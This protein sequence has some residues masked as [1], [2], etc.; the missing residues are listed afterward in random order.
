MDKKLLVSVMMATPVAAFAQQ[1]EQAVSNWTPDHGYLVYGINATTEKGGWTADGGMETVSS[2]GTVIT[3]IPG[4]GSV[5]HKAELVKGNYTLKVDPKSL[6]NAKIYFNDKL[7][8]LDANG[9]VVIPENEILTE[10]SITAA[11]TI[12]VK[13]I[14]PA[15]DFTVGKITLTLDF[16]FITVK[17]ALDIKLKGITL[18]TI[19]ESLKPANPS[20]EAESLRTQHGTLTAEVAAIQAKIDGIDTDDAASMESSYKTYEFEKYSSGDKI[21]LEIDALDTKVSEYNAAVTAENTRYAKY[22]SDKAT[23]AGLM[24]HISELQTKLNNNAAAPGPEDPG[25]LAYAQ[26]FFDGYVSTAQTALDDYKAQVEAAYDAEGDFANVDLSK[27]TIKVKDVE[28]DIDAVAWTKPVNDYNAYQEFWGEDSTSEL[29]P[30][31]LQKAYDDD[32]AKLNYDFNVDQYKPNVPYDADDMYD[33]TVNIWLDYVGEVTAKLEAA[34]KNNTGYAIVKGTIAGSYDNLAEA[35]EEVQA[36]LKAFEKIMK[37]AYDDFD[38]QNAAWK[39]AVGN[40][41]G[42][43]KQF[44][45]DTKF[46]SEEGYTILAQDKKDAIEAAKKTYQDALDALWAYD[47][48][49]HIVHKLDVTVQDYTDLLDAVSTAQKNFKKAVGDVADIITYSNKLEDT[50]KD[51]QNFNKTYDG[52]ERLMKQTYDDLKSAIANYQSDPT[53]GFGET[54]DGIETFA[55]TWATVKSAF[56]AAQTAINECS[57]ELD[58]YKTDIANA[59]ILGDNDFSLKTYNDEATGFAEKISEKDDSYTAQ[60]TAAASGSANPQECYKKATAVADQVRDDKLKDQ[61]VAADLAFVQNLALSNYTY[62]GGIIKKIAEAKVTFAG[63]PGIN[64]VTT[65]EI[66]EGVT[67]YEKLDKPGVDTSKADC[68]VLEADL[69]ALYNVYADALG[70]LKIIED[71]KKAYA[72]L[73]GA[74]A[75][76]EENIKTL[77]ENLDKLTSYPATDYYEKNEIPALQDTHDEIDSDLTDAHV[78]NDENFGKVLKLQDRFKIEIENLDDAIKDLRDAIVAN[79]EAY[80]AQIRES[81]KVANRANAIIA[82][83]DAQT[84][85]Q[86]YS[87][88]CRQVIVEVLKD[89]AATNIEI[90]GYFAKGEAADYTNKFN[91]IFTG[92]LQKINDAYNLETGGL[93]KAVEEYNTDYLNNPQLGVRPGQDYLYDAYTKAVETVNGYLYDIKNAGYAAVLKGVVE[94]EKVNTLYNLQKIYNKIYQLTKNIDAVKNLFDSR[95]VILS[96]NVLIN[97]EGNEDLKKAFADL[98]GYRQD[99]IDLKNEIASELQKVNDACV[100]AAAKY[101]SKQYALAQSVLD[102]IK[103][104]FAKANIDPDDLEDYTELDGLLLAADDWNGKNMP[105][106]DATDDKKEAYI[107]GLAAIMTDDIDVIIAKNVTD[108]VNLACNN[109]WSSEYTTVKSTLT[110]LSKELETY[111]DDPNLSART[112]AFNQHVTKVESLNNDWNRYY[113]YDAVDYLVD[114]LAELNAE[115]AAAQEIVKQSKEDNDKNAANAAARDLL[116]PMIGDLDLDLNYLR[117]YGHSREDQLKKYSSIQTEI[118]QLSYSVAHNTDLAGDG[119]Y[120]FDRVFVAYKYIENIEKI[121]DKIEAAYEDV[122]KYEYEYAE[123]LL[124]IVRT[125]FNN[126]LTVLGADNKEMNDYDTAINTQVSTLEGLK[127]SYTYDDRDEVM[128]QLMNVE[129]AL[130]ELIVELQAKFKAADGQQPDTHKAMLKEVKEAFDN[131]QASFNSLNSD[132]EN[133]VTEYDVYGENTKTLM[134]GALGKLQSRLD[135]VF[136][137]FANQGSALITDADGYEYEISEIANAIA[138]QQT[139]Y[140]KYEEKDSLDFN[141]DEIYFSLTQKLEVYKDNVNKAYKLAVEANVAHRNYANY[142]NLTVWIEELEQALNKKNAYKV[143]GGVHDLTSDDNLDNLVK[144]NGV[145]TGTSGKADSYVKTTLIYA[146]KAKADNVTEL[147]QSG[148]DMLDDGTYANESELKTEIDDLKTE[149]ADVNYTDLINRHWEY[150]YQE[151]NDGTQALAAYKGLLV[152]FA[153]LENRV[154]GVLDKIEASAYTMGDVDLDGK[155]GIQD[156]NTVAGW[157][158]KWSSSAEGLFDHLY[159]GTLNQRRMALAA[160]FEDYHAINIGDIVSIVRLFQS[161]GTATPVNAAERINALRAPKA[162][163]ENGALS[164]VYAGEVNGLDRYA[165]VLNNPAELVA[166]QF[167]INLP[168]GCRVADVTTTERSS[169]HEL[170]YDDNGERLRILLYSL[171]NAAFDGTDGAIA[172]IDVEGEVPALA[173][174]TLADS[175]ARTY[176][177]SASGTT[178]TDMIIEGASKAKDMI[179]DAAGRMYDKLQRG[180]NIIRNADGSTTKKISK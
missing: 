18:E 147:A 48:E 175:N 116:T 136:A 170:G 3:C 125:A 144:G 166:G 51:I 167:D 87:N 101:F 90:N 29:T 20:D 154:N 89:L 133:G 127:T 73:T 59:V 61:I 49:K 134:A 145:F 35:Q 12:V 21:D 36:R 13:H 81:D 66:P 158:L 63:E 156:I 42:V 180:I 16:N 149:I 69:V 99:A 173:Q 112:V 40:Y 55:T 27:L 94:D 130:C 32:F 172:F 41:E 60:L 126:A 128:S 124:P 117:E 4:T 109:K 30:A 113:K 37:D 44:N 88:E 26:D 114:E 100:D 31:K 45:D 50:W 148:I 75:A 132:V 91:E 85:L 82:A 71:N 157:I 110:Q 57:A 161:L 142:Y 171:E 153:D 169:A 43:L 103:I 122:Y 38:A 52:L 119:S 17:E 93:A 24:K 177:I 150:G 146:A 176:E 62:L 96:D 151:P 79:Q 83:L 143:V 111:V 86:G 84:S 106:A 47:A 178:I 25:C 159:N 120:S 179:Y 123:T 70:K 8:E 23:Y 56:I 53:I 64:K 129:Y 5:S 68:A 95:L 11:N 168:A 28:A 139:V 137:E 80:D 46:M 115:L 2:N 164:L 160:D 140:G 72:E 108:F 74:L 33:K 105:A 78:D 152:T 97:A 34:L 138:E 131:A 155:I 39:T 141:S 104:E 174:S 19:N 7:L 163:I 14:N 67:P 92:Y 9:E 107:D 22:L 58:T 165:L 10:S 77:I 1:A 65:P 102:E 162:T 76:A 6:E 15:L 135:A 121:R 118:D 54:K 98:Q